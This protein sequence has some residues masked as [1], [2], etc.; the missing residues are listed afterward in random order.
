MGKIRQLFR[1]S[2]QHTED[3]QM[4]KQS[5]FEMGCYGSHVNTSAALDYYWSLSS[6]SQKVKDDPKTGAEKRDELEKSIIAKL[7][8]EVRVG[9]R[10]GQSEVIIE[11]YF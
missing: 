11:K 1:W 10:S 7:S 4:I 6:Y 9:I 3:E 2:M 8:D 5:W